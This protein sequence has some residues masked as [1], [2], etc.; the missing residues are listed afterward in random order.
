MT[1]EALE[2]LIR[3]RYHDKVGKFVPTIY[4]N[5]SEEKPNFPDDL[6][7]RVAIRHG[8]KSQVQLG[9]KRTWRNIG[10]L[11]VQIFVKTGT[12]SQQSM[13]LA[14]RVSSYFK[15]VSVDGVTYKTPSVFHVGSSD[16]YYQMNVQ[17]PF[18]ADDLEA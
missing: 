4:D 11:F 9:E 14:D 8:E 18:Y 12:G 5:E 10:L 13:N 3:S 6:W 15:G 7:T 17:C 2:N 1:Y 16:G